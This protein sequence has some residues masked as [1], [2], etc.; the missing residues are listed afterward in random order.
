MLFRTTPQL[1]PQLDQVVPAGGVWYDGALQIASPQVGVLEAGSDG[2][3]YMWV[4]NNSAA[5]LAASAR[6]NISDDGDFT[7][8]TSGT[9]AWMAPPSAV[10]VGA[11]FWARKF[12][13]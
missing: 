11:G 7:V 10:P 2:H 13:L 5:E 12:A 1:G 6:I 3:T 4:V 9:G 8:S